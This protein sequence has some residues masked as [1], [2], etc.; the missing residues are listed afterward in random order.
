MVLFDALQGFLYLSDMLSLLYFL[1]AL[2]LIYEQD[3]MSMN[4]MLS[5]FLQNN[6]EGNQDKRK[7]SGQKICHVV[8]CSKIY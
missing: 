2:M 3:G 8:F 5:K 1:E 6:Q 4:D 7:N